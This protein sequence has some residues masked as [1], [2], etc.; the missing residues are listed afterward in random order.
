MRAPCHL[1]DQQMIGDLEVADQPGRNGAAAGLDAAGLVEKQDAATLSREIGRG[2]GAGGPAADHH[3]VVH[4]RNGHVA[5]LSANGS[6]K[7]MLASDR[8][9]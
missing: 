4:G 5:Y 9:G 6:A 1:R 7:A 3:D 8:A 2:G